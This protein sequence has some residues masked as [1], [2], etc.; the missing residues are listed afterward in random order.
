M[1]R[2]SRTA[3][4]TSRICDG[5]RAMPAIPSAPWSGGGDEWRS[6]RRWR[7][8]RAATV[9]RRR[10]RAWRRRRPR[11]RRHDA[12]A[13]TVPPTTLAAPT[14]TGTTTATTHAH[15]P[16]T[17]TTAAPPTRP[18]TTLAG[19]A[20]LAD[21]AVQVAEIGRSVDGRPIRAVERGTPGGTP[22]LVIGV[23][24]GD[25]HA[26]VADP[27][28]A[29][30]GA[31]AAGRRPVARRVDEPRRPGRP[32]AR[33]RRRRRPQPQLPGRLGADRRARATGSTPA[34]ARPASPRPRPS[35]PSST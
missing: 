23:I 2:S 20:G 7:W 14:T 18:P 19:V 4:T 24:H 35:S 16:P 8:R 26:G 11:P 3:R 22:V 13:T 30:D 15:R 10:R 27:R 1:G 17:T 29:G 6:R 21:D 5:S 12:V 25:E 33:Q 9:A 28:A 34:P 31:R 32:A